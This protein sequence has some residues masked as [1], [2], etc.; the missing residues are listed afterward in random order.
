MRTN[1]FRKKLRRPKSRIRPNRRVF[2]ESLEDRRLLTGITESPHSSGPSHAL[3]DTISASVLIYENG[4][5][6][7][8]PA[9]L[10][11]ESGEA[12]SFVNS[13]AGGQ[14]ISIGPAD[15]DGDDTLDNPA[16]YLTIGDLF[17]TW[18]TNAGDAGNNADADFSSTRLL[19]NAADAS[20]SV[21]MFV[22]GTAVHSYENYVIHDSDRIVLAYGDDPIVAMQFPQGVVLFEMFSDDAPGT[23]TNFLNY[24][25]DGDYTTSIVHRSVPGFIIQ[26]GG[27][28]S[29]NPTFSS[30]GQFASVPTDAAITN[31]F[32]L[33]NVRGTVAMAKLGGDPDSATSQ[34]FVNTADNSANLDN[35][36]GGFTVFA[37]VLDMSTVD[38]IESISRVN[39]GGAFTDLP[40]A[41]GNQLVIVD[42]VAGQGSVSGRAFDDAN[43]NNI[44]DDGEAGLSGVVVFS[45]VDSDGVLDSNEFSTTT[46]SDGLYQLKLPTGTHKI[47]QASNAPYRQTSPTSPINHV[48]TVAAGGE[49]IDTDFGNV[50]VHAP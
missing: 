22:N 46:D 49:H 32:S 33:S 42:S 1:K 44:H 35:Q 50:L 26:G 19:T 34:W 28:T 9:N 14:S 45:D 21:R 27:F 31:E 36:N 17:N 47:R 13:V 25:N 12:V 20:N 48:I 40:L 38:S 24:V 23:V 43:G 3:T 29:P 18:Q 11:V 5:L 7:D 39:A 41:S 16:D 15:I 10:G 6:T 8:L 37:Q 4:Q 2:L 30:V